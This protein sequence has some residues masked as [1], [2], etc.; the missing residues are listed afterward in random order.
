MDPSPDSSAP[1]VA[2]PVSVAVEL[3]K[4]DPL[5]ECL[6]KLA[7]SPA[8]HNINGTNYFLSDYT[9]YPI[10]ERIGFPNSLLGNAKKPTLARGAFG[11]VNEMVGFLEH[12]KNDIGATRHK[13]LRSWVDSFANTEV[14]AAHDRRLLHLF[15][16]PLSY[17]DWIRATPFQP[18]PST[19]SVA[20]EVQ[21]RQFVKEERAK[22]EEERKKAL[23]E[24]PES[25]PF[26]LSK[27]ITEHSQ[28]Q[29]CTFKV[30]HFA[31]LNYWKVGQIIDMN[32][33]EDMNDELE[34]LCDAADLMI[35][36]ITQAPEAG[37]EAYQYAS[38]APRK[39]KELTKTQRSKLKDFVN[40]E[41]VKVVKVAQKRPKSAAVGSGEKKNQ[42]KIAVPENEPQTKAGALGTLILNLG[43]KIADLQDLPPL[44]VL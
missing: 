9:G 5:P 38:K 1:V 29:L 35:P 20:Q 25:A 31:P 26:N 13:A 33:D 43:E 18:A 27:W 40:S 2:S 12:Y 36:G 32:G 10:L 30:Q 11:S 39:W 24:D 34:P 41:K 16:G 14:F 19:I 3:P 4:F 23:E 6:K 22:K 28:E 15:G 42:K 21:V 37:H 17:D 8:I 7:I 44:P